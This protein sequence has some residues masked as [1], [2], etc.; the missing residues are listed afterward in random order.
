MQ[1]ARFWL[2]VSVTALTVCVV[3]ALTG[4]APTGPAPAQAAARG[5]SLAGLRLTADQVTVGADV[6][7]NPQTARLLAAF[8]TRLPALRRDLAQ[9][10]TL[11]AALLNAGLPAIHASR[12]TVDPRGQVSPNWFSCRDWTCGYEFDPVTTFEIEW[13]VWAGVL[14]GPG[15][16]CLFLGAETAGVAC[17]IAAAVWGVL[18]AYMWMPP[19]YNPHRCL[20][21]GE[22]WWGRAVVQFVYC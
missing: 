20:Y 15:L 5:S 12:V 11:S 9:G 2:R 4:S 22:G 8:N 19:S 18:S 13:L 1:R 17:A 16:V 21:A 6:A 7:P 3:A 14:V 10:E